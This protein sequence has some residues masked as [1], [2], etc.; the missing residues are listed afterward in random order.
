LTDLDIKDFTIGVEEEYQLI[1]PE[2]G[3]LRNRASAVLE[4]DWTG[5]IREEMQQTT[6]EV[7]TR[8]CT[9]ADDLRRE[10]AR[11]RMQAAVAA[12]SRGLRVVAA[13]L[14]P[15]THWEGQEFTRNEVYDRLR[16]EYRR[17][18][19]S[20]NIFGLHVHVAVPDGIDRVRLMNVLRHHL[21]LLI[22]LSGSSP[23]YLGRETGY[24]S[25]RSILWGRWPR[26][27]APPRFRDRE[28]YDELIH[29]LMET[30]R[31]DGPGRIYWGIRPHH[32]YPTLEF[33][34]ADVTPRF[35]DAVGLATL[36][37]ALTFAA[38]TGELGGDDAPESMVL[39][40][41]SENMWLAARDGIEAELVHQEPAGPTVMP[42]RARVEQIV[43]RVR[44][45]AP[46]G[47]D[48]SGWKAL[49][50][51]ASRGGAARR[52]REMVQRGAEQRD[53]VSWLADETVLGIGLDRRSEQ[54]D[55]R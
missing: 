3:E 21:P 12:E 53:L 37:R 26:T 54:R 41:M 47:E 30:K 19:D 43:E 50:L 55:A 20:Q 39:P 23:M 51:L 24:D 4:S 31:I 45:L 17:L 22:A 40:F 1:D 46:A 6:V 27:G 48:E 18:A 35:G 8:V 33:R 52:I 44:P 13:G 28:A 15:F 11:L 5:E 29:Q 25:Y 42:I 7:G 9:S 38:A 10:L 16:A 34:A 36:L 14:H 32:R 49:E 2:T